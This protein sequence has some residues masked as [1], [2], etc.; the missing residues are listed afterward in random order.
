MKVTVPVLPVSPL[1]KEIGSVE[2]LGETVVW[3]DFKRI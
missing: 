2:S 3:P 1:A